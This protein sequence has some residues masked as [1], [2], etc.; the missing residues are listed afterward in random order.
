MTDNDGDSTD[1]MAKNDN[2]RNTIFFA[3]DMDNDID[4]D[5]SIDNNDNEDDQVRALAEALAPQVHELE[6]LLS[7]PVNQL[8]PARR[9]SSLARGDSKSNIDDDDDMENE[10]SQLAALEQLLRQELEFAQD[11][12]SFLNESAMNISMDTNENNNDNNHASFIIRESAPPSKEEGGG[13]VFANGDDDNDD[14]DNDDREESRSIQTDETAAE[15][16]VIKDLEQ[17][18]AALS[19]AVPAP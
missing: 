15:E 12:S 3:D 4:I 10:W 5:Q 7:S 6:A 17:N 9:A 19:T 13:D 1:E 16:A 8:E 14:D 18:L 2:K 11:F